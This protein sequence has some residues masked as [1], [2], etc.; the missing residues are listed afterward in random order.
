MVDTPRDIFRRCLVKSM[1]LGVLLAT[2]VIAGCG[3]PMVDVSQ[4]FEQTTD[5]KAYTTYAWMDGESRSDI[6][7]G[8][9]RDIDLDN[10]IRDAVETE[11]KKKGFVKVTANPNILVKYHAAVAKTYYVTDFGMHYHEKVG[12]TDTESA[13]DGQLTIDFVDGERDLVVWRGVALTAINVDPNAS[14]VTKNVNRAVEKILKQYP[15]DPTRD[16]GGAYK[17][18]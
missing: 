4:K 14:I 5:F 1:G 3:G 6:K 17:V 11:M 7:V 8:G 18:E 9:A 12:W 16:A 2:L 13:R 15:P 10:I